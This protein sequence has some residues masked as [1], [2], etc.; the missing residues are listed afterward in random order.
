VLGIIGGGITRGG[1]FIVSVTSGYTG[2]RRRADPRIS[3]DRRRVR[4]LM[5]GHH[6]RGRNPVGRITAADLVLILVGRTTARGPSLV[7]PTGALDP[8]PVGRI[9]AR[10]RNPVGPTE[11][12]DLNLV[13]PTQARAPNPVAR[14]VARDRSRGGRITARGRSRTDLMVVRRIGRRPRRGSGP[15]APMR[16]RPVPISPTNVHPSRNDRPGTTAPERV[17]DGS[18]IARVAIRHLAGWRNRLT[19]VTIQ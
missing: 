14:K 1:R 10:G 8:N 15:V 2:R 17:C 12:L 16:G 4:D 13:G 19:V 3:G 5:C 6:H 7:G 18:Q 11:A 9:T